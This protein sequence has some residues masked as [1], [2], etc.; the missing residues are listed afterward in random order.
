M[1]TRIDTIASKIVEAVKEGWDERHPTWG[2]SDSHRYIMLSQNPSRHCSSNDLLTVSEGLQCANCGALSRD[3][4]KTWEDAYREKRLAGDEGDEGDKYNNPIDQW[5]DNNGW[6][7]TH[8][9]GLYTNPI[10]PLVGVDTNSGTADVSVFKSKSAIFNDEGAIVNYTGNIGKIQK[11]VNTGNVI[12]RLFEIL[13]RKYPRHK[14]HLT[15]SSISFFDTDRDGDVSF[16]VYTDNW[17]VVVGD[18]E[19]VGWRKIEKKMIPN[20]AGIVK[21]IEDS[22]QRLRAGEG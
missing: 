21:F 20:V 4:G 17:T 16:T 11:A 9:I 14:A 19:S 8:G 6:T 10:F 18:C 5:L 22:Q 15:S 3:H 12:G 7:E 13:S 2:P 1:S